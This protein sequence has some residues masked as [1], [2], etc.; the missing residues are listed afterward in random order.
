MKMTG[1]PAIRPHWVRKVLFC[2]IVLPIL[3]IY[4]Y[5]AIKLHAG[6]ILS[7]LRGAWRGDIER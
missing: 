3:G 4:V 7:D 5:M 2:V 6:E 1:F